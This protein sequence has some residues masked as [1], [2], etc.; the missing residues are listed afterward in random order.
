MVSG[1]Q[2]FDA[3]FSSHFVCFGCFDGGIVTC[4]FIIDF[5]VENYHSLQVPR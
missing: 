4:P 3:S 2:E 5:G 1:L